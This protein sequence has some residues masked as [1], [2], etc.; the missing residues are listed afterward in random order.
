[1]L[2]TVCKYTAIVAYNY[3]GERNEM[4]HTVQ[5]T[6]LVAAR[7]QV[8]QEVHAMLEEGIRARIVDIWEVLPNQ[9][10]TSDGEW[11]S[12]E[13]AARAHELALRAASAQEE[14]E[15]CEDNGEDEGEWFEEQETETGWLLTDSAGATVEIRGD[16]NS[17][18]WR[19]PRSSG[20]YRQQHGNMFF[21]EEDNTVLDIV[22]ADELCWARASLWH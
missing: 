10:R 16:W 13:A 8:L 18:T 3:D 7:A 19:G 20:T 9:H 22:T 5:C 21:R 11:H 1:M 2:D 12:T 17:G 6:D 4:Y 15:D 14:D